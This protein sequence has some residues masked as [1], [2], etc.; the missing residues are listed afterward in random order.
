MYKIINHDKII[1]VVRYPRF[2]R[3]LES[4]HIAITDKTSAHGIVGSD[5]QTIYSFGKEHI[6]AKLIVKIKEISLEEFN[7]LSSLLNSGQEISEDEAALDKAKRIKIS[8]L[9][10]I[11]KNKI[12]AGFSIELSDGNVYKFKLTVEDQLN[13]MMMENQLNAG[14]TSFIYHAT[15]QPC[16]VFNKEDII[17]IIKAFKAHTLYHTTYFNAAKHYIKSLVNIEEVN[18]FVYGCDISDSV[19]DRVLKQILKNGGVD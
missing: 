4:G 14:V 1:D 11:C 2:V 13:L 15:D 6:Q 5:N 16:R 10:N 8:S 19:D 7:K 3:F 17:K 9:S 18:L 12:I